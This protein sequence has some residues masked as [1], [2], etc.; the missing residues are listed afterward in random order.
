MGE[1][2]DRIP[3]L[4]EDGEM[5]F[6]LKPAGIA[7]QSPGMPERLAAELGVE[8]VYPVHR[9]DKEASGV[10]V[11][12]KTKSAAAALSAA[13]ANGE[14]E[15]EYLA[16]VTGTPAP[17]G[18]MRDLLYHDPRRN[19]SFVVTRARHG[20]RE[21]IL[22]YEVIRTVGDR[23]LVKVR[24]ETGRTHQIRVQFASRGYPLIGDARYGGGK[25]E[26]HLF[27]H[28]ITVRHPK[29]GEPVTVESRPEWGDDAGAF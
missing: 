5:V 26:M 3:I 27:S 19:K 20:V 17:V 13:I 16:M 18:E 23:S 24:L 4:W 21:A 29:T 1:I 2:K 15:K 25:G 6:A 12:A 9:L 14:M 7:S 10:M 22:T 8:T 11:Y 28:R